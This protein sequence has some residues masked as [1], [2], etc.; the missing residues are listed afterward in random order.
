MQLLQGLTA[1]PAA[2]LAVLAAAVENAAGELGAACH[3][4]MYSS[5]IQKLL[6]L[7][8]G[9]EQ[10]MQQLSVA[11]ASA[12][13]HKPGAWQIDGCM[14]ILQALQAAPAAHL[15]VASAAVAAAA[16]CQTVLLH[17]SCTLGMWCR[18]CRRA[19]ASSS[20]KLL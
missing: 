2:Q 12:L 17:P 6:Q 19:G 8:Q 11:L 14:D 16:S 1:S 4:M 13:Q 15:E 10:L 3:P 9:N 18:C 7:C 20:S 5:S